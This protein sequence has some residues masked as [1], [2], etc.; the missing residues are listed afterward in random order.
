[1]FAAAL[2]D[3]LRLLAVPVLGWAAIRDV[4]TRRV[5]DKAWL[6]L[7]TLG[8]ILLSLDMFRVLNGTG[9]TLAEQELFL[10]RVG[11]S[12]G[13]PAPLG[14]MFWRFNLIGGADAKALIVIAV[15][16][17]VFPSYEIGALTFPQSTV[18]GVFSFTILSNSVLFGATYPVWTTIKNAAAG[19]FSLK[20]VFGIV[21][22]PT[23]LE[24]KYGGLLG[25]ESSSVLSGLDLDVL[26]MYLQWRGITIETIRSNP[27]RYRD[28]ETIPRNP[29][30]PGDGTVSAFQNARASDFKNLE[31]ME[32]DVEIDPDD[33]WGSEAFFD[34]MG[35][36]IYGTTPEDLE[37]GLDTISTNSQVWITPGT[38]FIVPI[39]G[40]LLISLLY[41]DVLH[42]II[43]V[44]VG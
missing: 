41:G 14:Y 22:K 37:T 40:G 38:P 35:G 18:L 9:I 39:F 23:D 27:D 17:P 44:I 19:Q 24:T 29:N 4:K 5:P 30:T 20:M 6:P 11:I 13:L 15:L 34:M 2:T 12:L 42:Q 26:R 43:G 36:N 3:L 8:V 32:L 33:A 31:T 1:V 21:M 7:A 10:M 16:F 25:T 28:P